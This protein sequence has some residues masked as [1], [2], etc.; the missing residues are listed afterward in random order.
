M[1]TKEEKA[2]NP[3]QTLVQGYPKALTLIQEEMLAGIKGSTLLYY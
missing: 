3:C 1:D 2:L